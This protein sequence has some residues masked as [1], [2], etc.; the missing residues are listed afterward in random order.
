VG[1]YNFQSAGKKGFKSP[2]HRY[3]W[4]KDI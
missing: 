4:Y 1:A 2:A 3:N